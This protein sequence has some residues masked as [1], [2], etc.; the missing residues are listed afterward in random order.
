ML[1]CLNELNL[2]IVRRVTLAVVYTI[3][4]VFID[5]LDRNACASNNSCTTNC[6]H[7]YS[8]VTWRGNDVRHLS[9]GL[10][11]NDILDDPRHIAHALCF[12]MAGSPLTSRF[13][14]T[15]LPRCDQHLMITPRANS[16]LKVRIHNL[17]SL[18]AACPWMVSLALRA[19]VCILDNIAEVETVL[20]WRGADLTWIT[21]NV[22]KLL[23]LLLLLLN[24]L[25]HTLT[26]EILK[27][28]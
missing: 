3:A 7:V 15:L 24:N 23:L 27:I 14:A 5:P 21:S 13:V 26:S 1:I 10:I 19:T 17:Q 16:C 18:L 20:D 6:P 8:I 4:D 28:A 11:S 22:L 9:C 2:L 25:L 12:L